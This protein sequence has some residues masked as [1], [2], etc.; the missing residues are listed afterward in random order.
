MTGIDLGIGA[1]S[2]TKYIGWKAQK[3]MWEY[4]EGEPSMDAFLFDHNSMKSGW[5]KLGK[6]ISPE[7]VWDEKLG[8]KT[9]IPGSDEEW[10]RAL[11]VELY[12]PEEGMHTMATV[13][14]GAKQGLNTI[15]QKIMS[16]A[17]N[18]KDLIPCLKY[19]DALAGERTSVPQ[20]EILKWVTKP[21]DWDEAPTPAQKEEPKEEP[22]EEDDLPF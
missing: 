12:L 17:S 7:Y 3:E 9:P 16:E 6:G 18:N 11:S 2:Q 22:K 13:G 15:F 14:W 1:D 8:V 19:T 5:G 21:A 10:K 20:F 4:N